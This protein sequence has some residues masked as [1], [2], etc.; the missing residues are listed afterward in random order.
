MGACFWFFAAVATCFY[1]LIFAIIKQAE[2]EFMIR[3]PYRHSRSRRVLTQGQN[4]PTPTIGVTVTST[5]T[6]NF[7]MTFNQPVVITG[8]IQSTVATKTLVSQ[9]VVSSTVVTQAWS[10]NVTGL[11]YTVPT[12]DPAVRSASGGRLL[13]V[14]G[15]FP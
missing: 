2:E 4:P 7:T 15:T 14:A 11:A 3:A 9:T 12:N 8:T 10:G 5:G 6:T 1:I 13:G